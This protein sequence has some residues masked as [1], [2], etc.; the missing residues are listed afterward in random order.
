MQIKK[1]IG[2]KLRDS[3]DGKEETCL[4]TVPKEYMEKINA[5]DKPKVKSFSAIQNAFTHNS[6]AIFSRKGEEFKMD[7]TN[8]DLIHAMC[9]YFAEEKAFETCKIQ[10]LNGLS[11]NKGLMLIGSYGF[12]K[13]IL[14]DVFRSMYLPNGFTT[15]ST[16]EI[17]LKYQ[18][19]GADVLREYMK[20]NICLDD[21]G[22][23]EKV[24]HYE[25]SKFIMK[26]VLEERYLQHQHFGWKTHASTNLTPEELGQKYGERIYSR[27]HELFNFVIV[28]GDDRRKSK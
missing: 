25:Q 17:S 9:L 26:T 12:G 6:H 13:S 4:V 11:L 21:L 1:G 24:S 23:E 16:N 20:H 14:F 5:Q 3:L 19:Q 10:S 15:A 7:E 18:E 27:L 28:N 8:T 2:S 22:S